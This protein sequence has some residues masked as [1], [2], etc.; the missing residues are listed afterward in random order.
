[1]LYVIYVSSIPSEGKGLIGFILMAG[2]NTRE[3]RLDTW[4]SMMGICS[5]L[6]PRWEYMHFHPL[7]AELGEEALTHK[8]ILGAWLT[9]YGVRILKSFDMIVRG[10]LYCTHHH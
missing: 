7:L 4:L 5:W 2:L 6:Q 8:E 9:I 10:K 3:G 1:M